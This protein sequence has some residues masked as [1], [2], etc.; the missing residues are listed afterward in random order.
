[1]CWKSGA[2]PM[3]QLPVQRLCAYNTGSEGAE[4]PAQYIHF[5]ICDGQG[6]GRYHGVKREFL[7]TLLLGAVSMNA[8]L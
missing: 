1:V 3:Q 5:S 2:L 6:V 8:P 4:R 7:G